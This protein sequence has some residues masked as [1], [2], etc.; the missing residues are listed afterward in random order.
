[1]NTPVFHVINM[2][3]YFIHIG[4]DKKFLYRPGQA[5]VVPGG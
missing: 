5:L 2:Y 1:M 3:K 4:K